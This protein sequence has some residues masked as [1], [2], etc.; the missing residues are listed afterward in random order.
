[1]TNKFII[2]ILIILLF[3]CVEKRDISQNTVISHILSQ[4]DGLHPYN[5]NSIMR[6]YVFNYTQKT[7]IQLDFESLDYIPDLLKELPTS[8][9]DNKTFYFE[10]KDN[11][12][13]DDGS[14]LTAKDVEFSTKIMLCHLTDNSQIRP[15]YTS[16]I[17]SIEIDP[18]NPLKFS[19][20]AKDV[21]W[22]AKTILGGIYIQQRS[23]WDPE[24]LFDNI[25]FEEIN[26]R[27]FEE[28]D[29]IT[30]WF[31]N[32]NHADN[33]FK[34]ERLKGL[35]PYEVSEWEPSQYITLKK[36]EFLWGSQES[37]VY[38]NAFPEKIIFKIIKEDASSYLA[39]KNQEIDVTINIGTVKLMKLRERDY[40][41]KNYDS[42]FL[43]RYGISYIGLNTKPDG[44]KHKPFFVDKKVRRAIAYTIPIDEI[45]EVMFHGKALRQPSSVSPLKKWYNDTLALIPLDIDKAK[46]LLTEAGWVDT[47]GDNIRDKVINGVKTPFSFKF[48]YMSSPISKEIVL[49]MKESMYKAGIVAEPTPMDFSL[50]YKNAGDHKFDAMLAG[51]GSSKDIQIQCNYGTLPHG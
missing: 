17:K 50:F 16:V 24:G 31:N 29:K 13:W 46:Q 22:T 45:I 34:P 14:L 39:L 12:K 40:F 20:Q 33:G 25:S 7:L 2:S 23:Y 3:S 6:S 1:M 44:I 51:W 21:N 36:K 42:D 32:F 48:S 41:N 5:N 26:S 10:L 19:M 28:T 9:E 35:G 38:N 43:D 37:S 15:I 4:P 27:S 11:I 47:D 8:S 30:D 49:M 18:N